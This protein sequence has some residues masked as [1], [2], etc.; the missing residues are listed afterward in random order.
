MWNNS[1]HMFCIW[2][3]KTEWWSLPY[4]SVCACECSILTSDFRLICSASSCGK[5]SNSFHICLQ[6]DWKTSSVCLTT[7]EKGI[8]RME[9][10][11]EKEGGREKHTEVLL[12]GHWIDT[13]L[14][15]CDSTT[16]SNTA[17][18]I[19][20]LLIFFL[21]PHSTAPLSYYFGT[22]LSFSKAAIFSPHTMAVYAAI[23]WP[24]I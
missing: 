1:S 20:F 10:E 16:N 4:D 19:C 7:E 9:E 18:F 23:V 2:S 11:R 14:T 13:F 21:F 6:V 22:R 17:H 15:R 12:S 24:K 8:V 5:S 3:R